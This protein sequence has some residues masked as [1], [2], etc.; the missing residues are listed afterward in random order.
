MSTGCLHNDTT[1]S[2]SVCIAESDVDASER[3]GEEGEG[4]EITK[5]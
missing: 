4:A 3:E 2:A 5:L 1:P